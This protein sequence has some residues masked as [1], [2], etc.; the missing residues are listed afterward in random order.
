MIVLCAWPRPVIRFN[1]ILMKSSTLTAAASLLMLTPLAAQE[2]SAT[3]PT[4]APAATV[5]Q[6]VAPKNVT[7]D[8]AEKL[9]SQRKVL[10]LDVRTPEEFAAGHIEGAVNVDISDAEFG[11]KVAA[12]DQTRPVLVHCAA[13]GRST[14]SLPTIEKTKFPAI[15]HLNGGFKEWA[16]EKKPVVKGAGEPA[17]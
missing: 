14:R 11:R 9:I 15:F 3:A 8:E 6:G 13:G 16:A 1:L 2:K 12:L 10:V 7:A 5:N 17:K 4:Q